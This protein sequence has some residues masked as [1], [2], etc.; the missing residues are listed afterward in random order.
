[1]SHLNQKK[2]NRIEG[3][4]AVIPNS[5]ID[6]DQI[7]PA[8]YLK[9]T[10][11][12]GLGKQLFS[13]WRYL[14]DGKPNPEFV[15]NQQPTANA[16][17]LVCGDNFGCGSSR[18]H[19]PWAL[20]DFGIQVVISSSIADIFRNNAVKNG[21]LP[22]IVDSDAHQLLLAQNGEMISVNIEEQTIG[23]GEKVIEFQLSPFVRYCFMNGMDQLDFLLSHSQQIAAYE[24]ILRGSFNEL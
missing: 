13:H 12:L 16:K 21:L 18:E 5:N 23:C 14:P 11:K 15:L 1:M 9:T 20:V 2:I 8:E 17:I 6:T 24:K 3:K 22:I 19:A 10:N 7:I 4:V